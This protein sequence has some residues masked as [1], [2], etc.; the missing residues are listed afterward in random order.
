MQTVAQQYQQVRRERGLS[1]NHFSHSGA[2]PDIQQQ[3]EGERVIE[4]SVVNGFDGFGG[5]H[6]NVVWSQA[7][8]WMAYTLHN[9][10]VFESVKSRQQTVL[11]DSTS[12]L[13]TIAISQDKRLISVGEGRPSQKSGNSL[14]FLYDTETRKLINRYTFHQRGV[15]ALAFSNSG[16][17]LI[18]VGV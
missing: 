12:H 6:D 11:C 9:K 14:I 17:H 2:G 7:D 5:V 3:P 8:G 1:H 13:S 18:S 10:L 15:Q 4:P 16:Q